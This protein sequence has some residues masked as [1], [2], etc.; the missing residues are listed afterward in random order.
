MSTVE[1]FQT[2]WERVV[3][4]TL[5]MLSLGT[6]TIAFSV[7]GSNVDIQC[8]SSIE[9]DDPA[10]EHY[11]VVPAMT[12]VWVLDRVDGFHWAGTIVIPIDEDTPLPIAVQALLGEHW[13]RMTFA[14][15]MWGLRDLDDELDEI[16]ADAEADQ[17]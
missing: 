16:A 6:D 12:V 2:R 11:H 8:V 5:E 3:G 1:T 7:Q 15:Q 14:H 17:P 4:G 10:D 13:E 9:S